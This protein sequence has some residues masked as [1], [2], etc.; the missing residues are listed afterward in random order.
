MFPIGAPGIALI[1]L[2][3]L[4]A[5]TFVVDGSAHW[6]LVTST[7]RLLLYT[8]PALFLCVGLLTPYCAAFCVLAR[9]V[10]LL[11]IES[12][13]AFHIVTSEFMSAA[14]GLLG[15]GAYSLDAVLFGRRRL[16]R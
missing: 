16:T 7:P 8:V 1:L 14:L 4:V 13:D 9:L 11:D 12:T 15:P 5:A 10:L 3:L 6:S 2:R